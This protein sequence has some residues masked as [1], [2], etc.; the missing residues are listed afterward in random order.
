MTVTYGERR[1]IE[2]IAALAG[3]PGDR[4][5]GIG[6]DCAV[7]PVGGEGFQVVTT[8]TLVEGVHFDLA[9]HPPRLLGRKAAA[10]N[11]SDVA[12]MGGTPRYAL[13]SLAL[14]VGVSAELVDAFLAGFL[15]MLSECGAQ[16]V[17]G[18][19]VGS[20][21]GIVI[22]VTVLGEAQRPV[23][24]SGARPG[25]RVLVAGQPGRA[26]AGLEL[27]RQGIADLPEFARLVAAHL[28]PI[29]QVA[30][31]RAL[32]ATGLVHAMQDLS[33][34]LATDLAHICQQSG[35]SAVIDRQRLP[36]AVDLERAAA[37]LRHDPLDW[38]LAGGEDF[39]LVC[40]AASEDVPA[41]LTVG[42]EHGTELHDIGAIEA[43]AG[44]WLADGDRR[45]DITFQGYE[46]L[47]SG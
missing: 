12:A 47:R 6:D 7:L 2:T 46:H 20:P 14:P 28:D 17:G 11:C 43:G 22:T 26:A 25:D 4:V 32:A 27:C 3:R 40:T 5:V 23:L 8:D 15:E 16:L 13:L 9:W 30:L 10:V 34:G 44:V 42:R 29:P 33:D 21:S 39:L 19:T 41:L 24:R 45:T 37:R 35:V 31:G 1:L 36:L 18:D 38:L